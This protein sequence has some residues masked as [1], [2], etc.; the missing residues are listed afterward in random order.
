ME[1]DGEGLI[2]IDMAECRRGSHAKGMLGPAVAALGEMVRAACSKR[3]SLA[4]LARVGGDV[5]LA[6]WRVS[7]RRAPSGWKWQGAQ[8]CQGALNWF[9]QGQRRGRCKVRRRAERV[10]RPAR[11]KNRRR[12][13]LVVTTCSPRPMRAVQRTPCTASQAPLA[14]K[15]PE[16]RWFSPTPYL[17]SRMAHLG[18]AA[19]VGFQF[20]GLPLPVGDAAVIAVGGKEGQLGTG[21]GLQP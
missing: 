18:V 1:R 14:A 15:R 13:V 20:Q 11:E 9:S 7:G 6:G 5:P 17:R 21:R 4:D 12:R 16:G 3:G 8:S 10:S 19:M 2:Q